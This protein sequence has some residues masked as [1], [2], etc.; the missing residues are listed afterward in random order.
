MTEETILSQASN[1]F[2]HI[3]ADH[4]A[5]KPFVFPF[6]VCKYVISTGQEMKKKNYLKLT[7]QI[8][9]VF[10]ILTEPNQQ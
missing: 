5:L 1:V 2:V 6:S 10:N 3:K 4:E 7:L 9:I 8:N